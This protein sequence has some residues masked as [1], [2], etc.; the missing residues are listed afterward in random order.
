MKLHFQHAHT[1]AAD[2][3]RRRVDARVADYAERY[4]QLPIAAAFT[5]RDAHTA[6]GGYRGGHG[7]VHLGERDVRIELSLPFFARPFRARI[8]AFVAREMDTVLAS[9]S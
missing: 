4:P 3:L 7:V 5:W 9:P 6:V 2:E 8:E 1:L